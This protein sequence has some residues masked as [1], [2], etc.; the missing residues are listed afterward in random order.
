MFINKISEQ[1]IE[2]IT[3]ET[4][5]NLIEMLTKAEAEKKLGISTACVH[6]GGNIK[7]KDGGVD[8]R[9]S[10]SELAANEGFIPRGETVFQIKAESMSAEKIKTEISGS[11]LKNGKETRAQLFR[12]LAEQ[13]CAYI[14]VSSKDDTSHT[15]RSK[16]RK[17]IEDSISELISKESMMKIKVDFYCISKI[18]NWIQSHNSV[19]LWLLKELGK[20]TGGWSGFQNWS[21]S[22]NPE[23]Y[24][25]TEE[26]RVELKDA[27]KNPEQLNDYEAIKKIRDLLLKPCSSLRL[28]GLSGVGKTRFTEALFQKLNEDDQPLDSQRVIYGDYGNSETH[29]SLKPLPIEMVEKLKSESEPCILILDNCSHTAHTEITKQI[30]NGEHQLNFLSIEYDIREDDIPENTFVINL[31]PPS[32]NVLRDFL[33]DRFPNLQEAVIDKIYTLTEGN[34]RLAQAISS[35]HDPI[36]S[37]LE[38]RDEEIFRRLFWQRGIEEERLYEAAKAMSLVYSFSTKIENEKSEL[39]ILSSIYSNYNQNDL[40]KYSS[41]LKSKNLVQERGSWRAVL[42]HIIANWLAKK[43]LKEL[44]LEKIEE[45]FLNT[46]NSIRLKLSFARRLSLLG[47]SDSIKA[48]SQRWFEKYNPFD[49][50]DPYSL[51]DYRM[52]KEKNICECLSQINPALALNKI[53]EHISSRDI[54]SIT[55]KWHLAYILFRLAYDTNLFIDSVNLLIEISLTEKISENQRTITPLLEQL[56]YPYLNHTHAQATE[57]I[58]IIKKLIESSKQEKID[59]AFKLLGKVFIALHNISTYY[60][61]DFG[62]TV[63]D[64]G[65][66]PSLLNREALKKDVYIPFLEMLAEI[67]Q[68][69][70]NL[71]EQIKSF[72]ESYFIRLLTY[73]LSEVLDAMLN[74]ILAIDSSWLELWVTIDAELNSEFKKKKIKFDNQIKFLNKIRQLIRPKNLEDEIKVHVF[75]F[76]KRHLFI[77]NYRQAVLEANL[78]VEELG[79]RLKGDS[80]L[81]DKLLPD[82]LSKPASVNSFKIHLG[83]GLAKNNQN[84]LDTWDLLTAEKYKIIDTHLLQGYLKAI[85]EKDTEVYDQILDGILTNNKLKNFYPQLQNTRIFTQKDFDRLK[86]SLD[87]D[88]EAD[89]YSILQWGNPFQGLIDKELCEFLSLFK[90][91][92]K[93]TMT[94]L[95]FLSFLTHQSKTWRKSPLVLE[96]IRETLLEINFSNHQDISHYENKAL[97][98]ELVKISIKD[99]EE[100]TEKFCDRFIQY[101]DPNQSW[102]SVIEFPYT[103]EKILEYLIKEHPLIFLNK[104]LD[105]NNRHVYQSFRCDKNPLNSFSDDILL[106]WCEKE[107]KTR[108]LILS[109]CIELF[110]NRIEN[111]PL[112]NQ[113]NQNTSKHLNHLVQIIL[114]KV[115]DKSLALKN[116]KN[117][118]NIRGVYSGSGA[119]A[120]ILEENLNLLMTL[121]DTED[122]SFSLALEELQEYMQGQIKGHREKEKQ[123]FNKEQKF[124]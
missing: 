62:F 40:Y 13:Q 74:K 108:Y 55:Q 75:H 37:I 84:L 121:K 69:K 106:G 42:P 32:K 51:G 89:N 68:V 67:F 19:K 34:F 77:T 122:S 31:K 33:K 30:S 91:R 98:S 96:L 90:K 111:H 110:Q 105:P 38:L 41:K 56:F 81:L 44:T 104:F 28:V 73:D 52:M 100:F 99:S 43:A 24:H 17:A 86:E 124:E 3:D 53:S 71:R 88:L 103:I 109:E 94:V 45:I 115:S 82:L 29:S 64:Y 36:D 4:L 7:A 112:N 6:F 97:I 113:S 26:S 15:M 65:W 92:F 66:G 12:D 21:Q 95:E 102:H 118:L 58:T 54:N 10:S 79:N 72:I 27:Q 11:K 39:E 8:G 25:L 123:E 120:A 50:F 48:I 49:Q 76:N 85:S 119:G 78:N 101:F 117:C 57:K 60:D 46:E 80:K 59:L 9:V 23:T 16:R 61:H 14:I 35:N 114:A 2:N 1:D 47:A 20:E 63:R 93:L 107:P 70:E 22:S 116:F 5:R 87:L 83:R 18:L